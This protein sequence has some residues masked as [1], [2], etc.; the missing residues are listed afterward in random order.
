MADALY[1][2]LIYENEAKGYQYRLVLSEF[3]EVQ[4]IHLR[5]YYLT[6]DGE[7]VPSKEGASIPV[8]IQNLFAIL[9][10][11]IDLCSRSESTD[12]ITTYFTNKISD[13]QKPVE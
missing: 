11:L 6:Y 13:L 1:E 7:Y 10:A 3:R 4:Y 5:K 2:K 8:T 12:A 9:D